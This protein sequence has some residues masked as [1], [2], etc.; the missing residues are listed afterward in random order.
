MNQVFAHCLVCDTGMRNR[1]NVLV[2]ILST[3]ALR[4]L[5]LL[6]HV[7]KALRLFLARPTLHH[8]SYRRPRRLRVSNSLAKLRI[9]F[10]A[11][12]RSSIPVH[13][14]RCWWQGR[15]SRDGAA[16][17]PSR[18]TPP[19][20]A[21]KHLTAPAKRKQHQEET[22]RHQACHQS[23][24]IEGRKPRYLSRHLFDI[25]NHVAIVIPFQKTF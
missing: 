8:I 18:C 15:C 9:C 2:F 10:T 4:A 5:C 7:T 24:S 1:R 20:N 22:E 13:A 19:A 17:N 23:A 11:G 16:T 12:K 3:L 25:S 21:H 6:P 14:L